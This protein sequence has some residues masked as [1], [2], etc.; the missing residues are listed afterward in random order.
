MVSKAFSKVMLSLATSESLNFSEYSR[1]TQ[2][3]LLLSFASILLG[4]YSFPGL[5]FSV[6][7]FYGFLYTLF[8]TLVS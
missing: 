5:L 8:K 1:N 3:I 6:L 2:G 7:V 4:Y